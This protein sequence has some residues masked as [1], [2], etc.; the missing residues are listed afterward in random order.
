MPAPEPHQTA[1]LTDAEVQRA[2]GA[3]ASHWRGGGRLLT[4]TAPNGQ[5]ITPAAHL[6]PTGERFRP[7]P[8]IKTLADLAARYGRS[9]Q[10]INDWLNAPTTYLD[11]GTGAS[12]KPIDYLATDPDRVLQIAQAS[13]GVEW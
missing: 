3:P 1:L 10:G 6:E 9:H 13:W 4:L 12:L 5:Y 11:Y 2:T 7:R 8:V